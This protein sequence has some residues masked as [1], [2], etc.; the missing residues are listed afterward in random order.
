MAGTSH[1]GVYHAGTDNEGC[2]IYRC[3]ECSQRVTYQAHG[4]MECRWL[5]GEAETNVLGHKVTGL[6]DEVDSWH[7]TVSMELKNGATQ[8]RVTGPVQAFKL[9]R[10]FNQ[11]QNAELLEAERRLLGRKE[12]A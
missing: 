8:V 10:T 2:A 12:E 7:R 11:V 9:L 5:G 3:N 1:A 6:I 4:R